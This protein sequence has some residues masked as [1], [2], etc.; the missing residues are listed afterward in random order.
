MDPDTLCKVLG[1]SK[2]PP[3][4]R[5]ARI[6]CYEIKLW[7]PYPALLDKPLHPVDGMV[8]GLLSPTQL[9]RL[10]AYETDKYRLKSCLI[11]VLNNDGGTEETIE[12]VSLC[13]MVDRMSFGR[14]LLT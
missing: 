7:G 11:N 3:M 1:S 13:G 10:A 12:G 14:V 9:D 6:I 4:M 5:P 8:C 2:P